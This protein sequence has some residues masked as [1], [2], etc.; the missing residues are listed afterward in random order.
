MGLRFKIYLGIALLVLS[1]LWVNA[2]DGL[3]CRSLFSSKSLSDIRLT[4]VPLNQRSQNSL[5]LRQ[6]KQFKIVTWNLALFKIVRPELLNDPQEV[7][8]QSLLLSR[9][10][11]VTDELDADVYVFQEVTNGESIKVYNEQYMGGRYHIYVIQGS[12]QS[13][14]AVAIKKSL[15]VDIGIKSYKDLKWQGYDHE[16]P[17]FLRDFPIVFLTQKNAD[18][19]TDRSKNPD[20]IIM[21]TH[22]KSKRDVHS[23]IGN[24]RSPIIDFQSQKWRETED[25]AATR[26]YQEWN[27]KYNG[28]V[29][30]VIAG[31]FNGNVQKDAELSQLSS[32]TK[33]SLALM[34]KSKSEDEKVTHTLHIKQKILDGLR[35]LRIIEG[36]VIPQQ[37]DAQLMN[38][39]M[40]RRLRSSFVYHYKNKNGQ[41]RTYS[42]DGVTKNYPLTKEQR[43]KAH[44]D[45]MPV[46]AI[47]DMTDDA[48]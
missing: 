18:G 1:P 39:A 4:S 19:S 34:G 5:K 29:P 46:V 13:H 44:F 48:Q 31:D 42:R 47:Y 3:F 23:N 20:V 32:I 38:E 16:L 8:K 10:K 43:E 30:I 2:S 37:L 12:D 15:D 26:I 11:Q 21:G 6:N 36:P 33:D 28:Q 40:A 22:R 35:R 24:F 9:V 27:D 41:E 14:I 7:Q 45:H 17:V 25:E